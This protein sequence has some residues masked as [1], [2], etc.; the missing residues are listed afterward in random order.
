MELK[1]SEISWKKIKLRGNGANG[2]TT[3]YSYLRSIHNN[4]LLKKVITEDELMPSDDLVDAFKSLRPIVAKIENYDYARKFNNLREFEATDI[5]QQIIEA[6]VQEAIANIEITGVNFSQRQ[7]Q[8]G[9]IISYSKENIDGK[10]KG[11]AT[12]WINIDK[13]GIIV[14]EIEDDLKDICDEIKN[15]AYYYIVGEKYADSAQLSIA[16]P[17]EDQKEKEADVI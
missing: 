17:E 5:Q 11:S 8:E 3:E 2:L 1:Q 13:E 7:K 14:Y 6:T 12:T 10:I 16:Y 9:V 4:S 15:E